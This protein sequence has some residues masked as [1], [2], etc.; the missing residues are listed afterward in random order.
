MIA[1]SSAL[2]LIGLA[3]AVAAS[4]WLYLLRP[5]TLEIRGPWVRSALPL[6][7]IARRGAVPLVVFVLV[8]GAAA[9]LLGLVA[10]KAGLERLVAALA[11][12]IGIGVWLYAAQTAATYLASGVSFHEALHTAAGARVVYLPA[13]FAGI[14]G[15]ILG[16]RRTQARSWAPVGSAIGVALAGLIDILSAVTPEITERL[17]RVERFVPSAVP[18]VASAGVAAAGVILLL[19]A[20]GL[21]RRKHRAWQIAVCLLAVSSLLHLVKGLDYEEAT[22]T[23]IL[24]LVLIARRHDFDAPGDTTTRVVVLVRALVGVCAIYVYGVVALLINAGNTDRPFSLGFALSVTSRALLGGEFQASHDV[25]GRFGTWFPWSISLLA[26]TGVGVLVVSWLAPWRYRP[27]EGSRHQ[28]IAH[29]LV[30]RWGTDTLSP[31]SLRSDKSTFLSSDHRAFVA[32]V[33]VAGVALV[34]GDPVGPEDAVAELVPQFLGYAR[35]RGWTVAFLGASEPW[36]NLAGQFGL[37][38]M[39]WG[40]EAVIYT[41]AFSLDGR[42]IRKVRQ[43]VHRLAR[44]GYVSDIRTAAQILTVERREL[45]AIVGVWRGDRAQHGFAMELNGL[46]RLDGDDELFVIGRDP[47]GAPRGFLHFVVARAGS[48]LSLSSMPRLPTTPNGFNEWLT[49]AAVEWARIQGFEKVSLNF[50]AFAALFDPDA[51]LSGVRRIER[52]ALLAVRSRLELQLD[53]LLRFTKKFQ[54]VWQSRYVLYERR[55]DLPRIGLAA[56]TAEGYLPGVER[57]PR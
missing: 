43:S 16:R 27:H 35:S 47:E 2:W 25:H 46:F 50:A 11:L 32:Y 40:D 52:N 6:D 15:G 20:R 28:Q 44:A 10:R 7:D 56:L 26:M 45:E 24:T 17:F 37:H 54:P 8:W 19:V 5:F 21:A 3:I 55:S 42:A 33:V 41:R 36:M 22:I 57:K 34:G 30:R 29:E 38:P 53:N 4:G 1:R 48:A 14:A 9:G 23:F 39:Y 18:R 12:A 49:C 13:A 51:E 31:F